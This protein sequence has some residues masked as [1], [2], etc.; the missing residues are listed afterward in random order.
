MSDDDEEDEKLADV[1]P[2]RGRR[3][4]QGKS[5]PYLDLPA[6]A[7]QIAAVSKLLD[8]A[9]QPVGRVGIWFYIRDYPGLALTPKQAREFGRLLIFAADDIE[10]EPP[11]ASS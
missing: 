3:S 5:R 11:K 6:Y 10:P 2:I 4:V 9:G 8:A 1:I 7:P